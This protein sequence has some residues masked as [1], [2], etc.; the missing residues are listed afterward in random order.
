M[1]L[2]MAQIVV[3]VIPTTVSVVFDGALN[4]VRLCGFHLPRTL[5]RGFPTSA[6]STHRCR[7]AGTT[8]GSSSGFWWL[9]W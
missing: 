4:S 1:V 5:A 9:Q 6:L 7:M 8:H 3:M 2:M